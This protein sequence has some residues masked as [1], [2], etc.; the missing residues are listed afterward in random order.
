MAIKYLAGDRQI[1]TAAERTALSGVTS[2]PQT[3]WKLLGSTLTTGV[4]D[5]V[6][7]SSFAAKDN[8]MILTHYPTSSEMAMKTFLQFNGDSSSSSY[9]YRRTDNGGT[10]TAANNSAL[11]Y[12]GIYVSNN[13]TV[14]GMFSVT[15]IRNINGKE[16]LCQCQSVQ[17][18]NNDMTAHK[19]YRSE[20]VG[21]WYGDSLN[22][23]TTVSLKAGSGTNPFPSGTEV[24]VLGCDDDEA[25]SGTNFWQELNSTKLT[26]N[27]TS[28]PQF[29]TG[30]FAAK[31]YLW[32]QGWIKESTDP[33]TRFGYGSSGTLDTGSNYQW[34]YNDGNTADDPSTITTASA[35]WHNGQNARFINFFVA[36]TTDRWKLYF[37]FVN[38]ASGS[39]ASSAPTRREV[40][41]KWDKV[42]EQIRRI[43]FR[44][45][46]SYTIYAGS[47]MR[48]LGGQ[49]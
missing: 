1:G 29:D 15:Q 22:P 30:V 31:K 39:G 10:D 11:E 38:L 13:S 46:G 28:D 4:S 17:N 33:D 2:P 45:G 34:R 40:A 41:G 47:Q 24:V 25:D 26:S 32:V 5:T 20:S 36:N 14:Y 8:L 37:G 42:S 27:S 49:P 21:K 48:V 3:S 44:S 19:T 23:I 16:K 12:T 35:G 6:T 9:V 43:V 7:V 18:K